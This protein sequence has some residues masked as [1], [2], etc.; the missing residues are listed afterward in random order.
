MHL[1]IHS[2]ALKIHVHTYTCCLQHPCSG[3]AKDAE[4][5]G[6]CAVAKSLG[7]RAAACGA[8][9]AGQRSH[10]PH[11]LSSE[12]MVLTLSKITTIWVAES[13]DTFPS[14]CIHVLKAT[15]H[16]VLWV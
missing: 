15:P 5:P 13:T 10:P 14:T 1:N 16:E 7:S 11:A 9:G 2:Q 8:S 3:D 6:L 12:V 4:I